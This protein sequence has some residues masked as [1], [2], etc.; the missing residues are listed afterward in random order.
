VPVH[1]INMGFCVECHTKRKA[2]LDCAVC[3][4]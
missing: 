4:H 1:E 2:P 3:H